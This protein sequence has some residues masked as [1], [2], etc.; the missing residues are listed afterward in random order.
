MLST[1]ST[2]RVRV[3][4][5]KATKKQKDQP[6]PQPSR[7]NKRL[8]SGNPVPVAEGSVL[9]P[10]STNPPAKTVLRTSK[11]NVNPNQNQYKIEWMEDVGCQLF[12]VKSSYRLRKIAGAKPDEI[13][14]CFDA[15]YYYDQLDPKEG[16]KFIH[17]MKVTKVL[18]PGETET[19]KYCKQRS[20]EAVSP[21][22]VSSWK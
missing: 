4:R 9:T 20:S 2:I 7:R 13:P 10:C 16:K 1:G 14:E 21:G 8:A 18:C 5:R 15:E 6:P 12:D 3:V 17:T 19:E 22:S 11:R